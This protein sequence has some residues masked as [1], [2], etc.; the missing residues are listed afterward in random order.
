MIDTRSSFECGVNIMKEL[1]GKENITGR[2]TEIYLRAARMWVP[3]MRTVYH[4]QRVRLTTYEVSE[5][6]RFTE[7]IFN[8]T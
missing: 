5:E 8:S 6:A 1:D 4:G 2:I 3:T 7:C